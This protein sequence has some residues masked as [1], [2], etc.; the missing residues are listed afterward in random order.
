MGR[1]LQ[2]TCDVCCKTMRSDHLKGHMKRHENKPYSI[3]V[4]TEKIEYDS[5]VDVVALESEIVNEYPRKLELGRKIKKIVQELNVP[6]ASLDK[7]KME[8]LELF[9]NHGQV[10]E[11]KH[12]EK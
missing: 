11:I 7:E 5:T 2:K 6:L 12:G 8:A 1:H 3:D 9:E 10:K 4:V